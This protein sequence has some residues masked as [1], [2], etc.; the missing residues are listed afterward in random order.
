MIKLKNILKEG[1]KKSDLTPVIKRIDKAKKLIKQAD[2]E[3]YAAR[4]Y[5][6]QK[7]EDKAGDDYNDPKSIERAI[8]NL[9]GSISDGMRYML[10]DPLKKADMI[11]D[12]IKSI[13]GKL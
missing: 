2:D 13:L 9:K 12:Q 7:L 6:Y 3:L 1:L 5:V 4:S 11:K 10:R 8:Y